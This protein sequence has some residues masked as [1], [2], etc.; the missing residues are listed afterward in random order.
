M[1][2]TV[3]LRLG[4]AQQLAQETLVACGVS[5][6]NALSTARALVRAEADGQVGH[7]MSR[8]PSYAA[9]ARS[10]KVYGNAVPLPSTVATAVVRIDGGLGFA[11]PAIDLAIERLV[12][13]APVS[14]IAAAAVHRSHH[15]GQAGAHVERLAER[16]LVAMLFGNSPKGMAFWGGKE[17]MLGTNPI[18]FAAP[19]PGAAPLVIDLALA[20]VARVKIM[21]AGKRGERI[22]EGWALDDQGQPTTDPAAALGG[23]MLPIGAAKGAAL[24]IM[25]ELLSAALTG[26]H[27]GWE[28]SSVL[29]A[30]GPPPELGQTLIAMAP[31]LFSN[32]TFADR[33]RTFAAA[34]ENT[35]GARL[36]GLSRLANRA[37]AERE[38]LTLPVA[39]VQEITALRKGA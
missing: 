26:S 2:Q 5:A 16:G 14:G 10:G 1:P 11:Y 33:M 4:A 25:V 32:A 6:G 27:F 31:E 24:A 12:A 22:P 37:R 7:G 39:L 36:P 3:T 38:G 30:E 35:T 15:F 19:L 8:V 28:A 18:A 20:R 34:V 29:D 9:Q 23:S 13:M 21:A 17:P